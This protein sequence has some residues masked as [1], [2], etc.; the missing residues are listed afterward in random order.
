[1]IDIAEEDCCW[2]AELRDHSAGSLVAM[3]LR[4]DPS[5]LTS[6]TSGHNF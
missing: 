1:M 5:D 6:Q 4:L 3:H 2:A